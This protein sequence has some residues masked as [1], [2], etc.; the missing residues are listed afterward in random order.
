MKQSFLRAIDAKNPNGGSLDM[1]DG[2]GI[3][4]PS[5][6]TVI[7]KLK[8]PF[9]ALPSLLGVP[10]YGWILP[11]EAVAGAYD[12]AKQMIGSGPF[13]FDSYAPDIAISFKRNPDWFEKGRPYIDGLRLAI[14]P[15]AA[16][17]DGAVRRRQSR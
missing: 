2:N 10:L 4:T 16:A 9:A 1:I 7:F 12:P 17:T 6:D 13:I 14:I 11:R 15:D 8:Y 5:S 3:Q